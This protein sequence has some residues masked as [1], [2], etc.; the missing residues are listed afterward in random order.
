VVGVTV[1][2]TAVDGVAVVVGEG[3]GVELG[4]GVGGEVGTGVGLHNMPFERSM[5]L[6]SESATHPFLR[7]DVTPQFVSKRYGLQACIGSIA[8]GVG[9]RRGRWRR[10]R[11]WAE[12]SGAERGRAERGRVERRWVER[13]RAERRRG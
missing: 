9:P 12:R 5:D 8:G 2:G 3:V 4:A 13:G 11:S 1:D 10:S 7:L 6:Y